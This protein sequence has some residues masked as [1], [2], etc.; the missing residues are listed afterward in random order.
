[1]VKRYN[2]YDYYFLYI[3]LIVSNKKEGEADG[4]SR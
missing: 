4:D 1:M 3:K 2:D